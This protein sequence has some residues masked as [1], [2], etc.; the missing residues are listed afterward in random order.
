M[1]F[2]PIHAMNLKSIQIDIP[3]QTIASATNIVLGSISD[4]SVVTVASNIISLPAGR[5]YFITASINFAQATG[6]N[7]EFSFI[8]ASGG[9]VLSNQTKAYAYY[10]ASA[11]NTNTYSGNMAMIATD[12]ASPLQIQIKKTV[13]TA[14]TTIYKD[15][16]S[17][18][19][20]NSS[21]TIL[22]TD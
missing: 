11:T 3:S 2:N 6:A 12:L 16:A 1:T 13:H 10:S 4:S 19:V 21:I 5:D 7:V 22:Y 18:Y 17:A 14:T 15:N 9:A 20:A 8:N